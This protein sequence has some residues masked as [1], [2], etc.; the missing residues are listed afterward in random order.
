MSA[1]LDE[2]MQRLAASLSAL[3]TAAARRLEAERSRAD[4]ELELQIMG[5][6]RARLAVELESASTRLAQVE[7]AAE[8]VGDRVHHAIGSIRDVLTRVDA[9]PPA[10]S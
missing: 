8:H 4:L 2:A 9:H 10:G 3:E 5:D 6:D 1:V 7:A